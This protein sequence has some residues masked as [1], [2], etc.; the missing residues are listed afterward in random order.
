LTAKNSTTLDQ[1]TEWVYGTTLS[2]SDLASNQLVRQKIYPDSVN[3]S[4]RVY[5]KWNR[6]SEPREFRDQATTVHTLQY[7]KLAR[8]LHDRVTTLA[9]GVDG[10]IRRLT[11]TYGVNGLTK[12]TSWD[13]AAVGSG[14]VVNEVE[15]V[16][17]EFGQIIED[18]Q[19]HA[20]A[21]VPA[22]TPKVQYQYENGSANNV[23]LKKII[24]PTTSKFLDLLYGTAGQ[25]DDILSRVKQLQFTQA[26]AVVVAE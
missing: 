9:S 10:A 18:R 2:D 14:A 17:N 25:Q 11:A 13:N 15:L 26:S 8:L 16:Y 19:S 7:D 5:L 23:R 1:V 12:L 21:V 22:S 24:Y 6:Q 20:G 4:D 3:S